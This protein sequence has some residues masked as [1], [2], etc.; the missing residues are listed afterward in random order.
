MVES[1]YVV[2]GLVSG[3]I[4]GLAS[5]LIVYFSR[6]TII[7]LTYDLIVLEGA[8]PETI[9]YVK[10]IINYAIMLSP[11]LYI[12][13]ML[14]IGA[15]FGSLEDYLVKKFHLKPVFA[16][17]ATGGVYVTF[18]MLIPMAT[19]AIIDSRILTLIVEHLGY[20]II[21]LPVIVF[22]ATLVFLSSTDVLAPYISEERVLE[23]K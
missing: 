18:L 5:G 9:E 3:V 1:K 22:I 6:E 20:H 10:P 2:Y 7:K 19:L 17:L 16:A 13:Q 11:I 12:I 23:E 4:S 8:P 15:I 14:I 21:A